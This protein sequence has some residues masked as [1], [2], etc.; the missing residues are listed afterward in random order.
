MSATVQLYIREKAQRQEPKWQTIWHPLQAI[1]SWVAF[2]CRNL[3]KVYPFKAL[4]TLRTFPPGLDVLYGQMINSICRIKDSDDI[5]LCIQILSVTLTIYRPLTLEEL[6]SFIDHP[7]Q[8]ERLDN[9]S[10]KYY[11][12]LYGSFLAIRDRTVYFVHHSVTSSISELSR[13]SQLK[14]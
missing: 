5:A 14:Y 10:L 13:I 8:D 9:N 4:K 12:K 7:L 3:D 1:H 11:A 6:M 2:I